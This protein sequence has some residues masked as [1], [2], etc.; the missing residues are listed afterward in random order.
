MFEKLDQ[1][2][3]A[4]GMI[5]ATFIMLFVATFY[6]FKVALK[7]GPI[8]LVEKDYYQIGLNYE[9]TLA[10]KKSLEK[11]G[12][13]FEIL[14]SS[15]SVGKNEIQISYK[16]GEEFIP[17]ESLI[18]VVEKGATDK[19]NQVTNLEKGNNLY[20]TKLDIPKN[21]KWLMTVKSLDKNFSQTFTIEIP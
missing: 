13:H 14:N 4:F 15:W 20:Y 17:N 6:T 2:K 3:I 7:D 9:K 18:L 5:L 8:Q 12:Y 21:G 16:K 19:Y 10:E 11:E 1:L